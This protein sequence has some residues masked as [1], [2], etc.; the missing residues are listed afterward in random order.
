MFLGK[1]PQ[2]PS[3]FFDPFDYYEGQLTGRKT[4]QGVKRS[5]LDRAC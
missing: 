5:I 1:F 3:R 2:L 4:S